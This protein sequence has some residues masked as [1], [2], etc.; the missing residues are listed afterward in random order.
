MRYGTYPDDA[1]VAGYLESVV[2]ERRE[3]RAKSAWG[4]GTKRTTAADNPAIQ[5]R[6]RPRAER[7]RSIETDGR[8]HPS[9]TTQEEIDRQSIAILEAAMKNKKE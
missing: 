6:P 8:S 2:K 5:P 1:T 9:K 4:R 7:T 3:S